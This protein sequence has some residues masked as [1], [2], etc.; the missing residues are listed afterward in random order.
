MDGPGQGGVWFPVPGDRVAG[1]PTAAG[2]V[3]LAGPVGCAADSA[4]Q[5]PAATG[6]S[7]ST[8][9]Q[10]EQG[11]WRTAG[12]LGHGDAAGCRRW[13]QRPA[14][15]AQGVC[16]HR[17]CRRP[18]RATLHRPERA[19]RPGARVGRRQGRGPVGA[20][21]LLCRLVCVV[22]SHG[23]NRVR[24]PRGAGQPAGR[25]RAAPRRN[26]EQCGQPRPA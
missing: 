24:Q 13:C 5:C 22:Q 8:A 6:A 12:A 10:P 19:G 14:A 15:A 11:R 18:E 25:T 23:E 3:D 21:G 9:H 7:G 26:R 16:R 1:D 2:R 4:G 20:G 17:R